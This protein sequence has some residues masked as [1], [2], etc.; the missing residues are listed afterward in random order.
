MENEE[1]EKQNEQN[2]KKISLV[3]IVFLGLLFGSTD[4]VELLAGLFSATL[5]LA[6]VSLVISWIFKILCWIA[7]FVWLIMKNIRGVWLISGSLL[8]LIPIFDVLPLR[9]ATFFLTVF[10]VNRP[11]KVP[12]AEKAI[13]A[14]VKVAEKVG[15]VAK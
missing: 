15:K 10:L 7:L 4:L 5:I 14:T 12:G 13:Q 3:E 1:T 6:P 2:Q 8:E 11:I 9:T